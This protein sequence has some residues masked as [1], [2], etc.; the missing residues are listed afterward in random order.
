[1][2]LAKLPP[3]FRTAYARTMAA[4]RSQFHRDEEIRRRT[5]V[6]STLASTFP[7]QAVKL[8]LQISPESTSVAA[9]RAA[10]ARQLRREGLRVFIETH[11]VA[12]MPGTH[13]FFRSLY[14]ALYLQGLESAKGGAGAR[15][16]EW[17]VD[18][19]VFSEAGG[20]E[21]WGKEAIEALKAV[22]FCLPS[23]RRLPSCIDCSLCRFSEC[24]R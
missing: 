22:R 2:T 12:K 4:V 10:K 3:S 20:G 14:A 11:C 9:M 19:A 6:E 16:V 21:S 18:V 1:M 13:P 24:R 17:E 5:A 23:S 15:C 8:G 7:G